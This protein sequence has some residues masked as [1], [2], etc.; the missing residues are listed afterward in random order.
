MGYTGGY[1]QRLVSDSVYHLIKDCLDELGWFDAGRDHLPITVRTTSVDQDESIA[2]NTLVISETNTNDDDAEMGSNLGE[3]VTVFWV[4]F[5]GENE[6]LAKELIHDVRDIL[7][8]RMPDIGRTREDLPVFDWGLATPTQIFACDISD[9]VVDQAR[10]FPKPWQ[11]HWW[12][13]RFDV[14]DEYDGN[15]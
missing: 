5:Y 2:F 1:R 9:I 7:R 10:D 3:I 13:C 4:D 15:G 14:T 12:T 8:G 6:S 11:R